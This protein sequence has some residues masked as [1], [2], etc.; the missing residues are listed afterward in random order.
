VLRP[1]IH[2]N[3]LPLRPTQASKERELQAQ[4]HVAKTEAE[5]AAKKAKQHL[6]SIKGARVVGI[7]GGQCVGQAR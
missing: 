5:A 6:H 7:H 2:P 1:G 3:C 4:L